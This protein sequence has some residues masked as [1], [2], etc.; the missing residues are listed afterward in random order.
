MSRPKPIILLN[1]EADIWEIDILAGNSYW[2]LTLDH[3]PVSIRKKAWTSRG[4]TFKY[5]RTGFNNQ[6]HAQ[7]LA[8]SLNKTFATDRFGVKEINTCHTPD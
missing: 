6:A 5:P 4:I 8:T 3:E 1:H 7:R 2:I